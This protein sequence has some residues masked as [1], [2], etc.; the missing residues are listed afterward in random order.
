MELDD[1]L[2]CPAERR[3]AVAATEINLRE[4]RMLLESSLADFVRAAWQLLEPGRELQWNWHIDLI[5]DYLQAFHERK[6]RRGI[7]NIPFR[8][9]KSLLVSCFFPAWVWTHSPQHQFLTLAHK[10]A[11]AHR[12]AI[13]TRVILESDWYQERWGHKVTFRSD[14]N[15]KGRYENTRN[16]H[17][18]SQGIGAGL[19]GDGGDTLLIDDPHDAEKAQSDAE[20]QTVLDAYDDKIVSRLNDPRS[21]GILIIMQRLHELDLVGHVLLAEREE[22]WVH[23]CLPMEYE[24]DT[25]G[26]RPIN[27][28]KRLGF[29]DPRK[30]SGDLMWK[31]RFPRK[32]VEAFKVRLGPYGA[33][34][35]LQQRPTPAGGGILKAKW[36]KRWPDGKP[37]PLCD[38]IFLSWDTAYSKEGLETNSFSAET[39]WG[40]FWHEAE[41]RHCI[42]LL[43]A[44]DGQVEYPDLRRKARTLD[45]ELD[46]DRHLIEKKASGQSL[47]QDLRRSGLSVRAYNPDRDK[48]A[49]AYAV[50]AMLADGQVWAPDRKWADRVIDCCASFPF[51]APPSSDY[52]D[53]C[54]QAWLYLRNGWWVEHSDD[55]DDEPEPIKRHPDDDDD[56][57]TQ[58]RRGF[59]G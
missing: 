40:I 31:E 4:E 7:I 21:G 42:I 8:C 17:R 24:A 36:W 19:T 38:Q 43:G 27:P 52:T 23:L 35:Q 9:M 32:V 39:T 6:F 20:R 14:Q 56:E 25:P 26:K 5:C 47:I 54:T 12:D 41:E 59:Y 11:L 10:D 2:D 57:E 30:K 13:K 3:A 45:R 1:V 53:T 55:E 34:G 50:Q 44:W 51:G 46:P 37:M 58:Q 29:K 28:A 18:I 48:I 22:G 49:R 15:Q 16:G 33:S